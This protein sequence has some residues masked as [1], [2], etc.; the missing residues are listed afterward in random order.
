MIGA[1]P[2]TCAGGGGTAFA[3]EVPERS[4]LDGANDVEVSARSDRGSGPATI[5]SA[6]PCA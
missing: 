1:S 4:F 2:Q 3:A 5:L 6:S